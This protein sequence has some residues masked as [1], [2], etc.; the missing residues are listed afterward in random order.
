M[1]LI[2]EIMQYVNFFIT[3]SYTMLLNA[4]PVKIPQIHLFTIF[5][6]VSLS[7]V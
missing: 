6:F 7:D 1:S 3:Y 2:Y 4:L 5:M